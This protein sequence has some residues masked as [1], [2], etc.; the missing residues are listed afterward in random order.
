[1]ERLAETI[2]THDFPVID[3]LC[4]SFGICTVTGTDFEKRHLITC[5]DDALYKAKNGG[6][7]RVVSRSL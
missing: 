4:C 1:M 2:R 6:K 5:A 3:K 7:D